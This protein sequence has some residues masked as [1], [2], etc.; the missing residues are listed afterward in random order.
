MDLS[1]PPSVLVPL[2]HSSCSTFGFFY[3]RAPSLAPALLS[4]TFALSRAFFALP[5]SIKR[6]Y[7]TNS[8]NRGYTPFDDETLHR[9]GEKAVRRGDTKEGF[10]IG[11]DREEDSTRPLYGR[12]MRVS[13]DHVSGWNEGMEAYMKEA[14]AVGLRLVDLLYLALH[15]GRDDV[16]NW[17]RASGCFDDPVAVLRPLHYDERMSS[18]EGGQMGA[19]AHCDYGMLTLLAMDE[20]P[21]LQICMAD[22]AWLDI[23]P[24][25]SAVVVNCGDM[26][27]RWSNGRYRSTLH[28][29]LNVSG[30]HRYSLPFFFE[31]N[32]DCVVSPLPSCCDDGRPP[33]FPPVTSGRYLMGRYSETQKR[34]QETAAAATSSR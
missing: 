9:V 12:N 29:V 23:P 1:L 8:A 27:E 3:L 14:T 5:D 20:V 25:E 31:P 19:G 2:L 10:Y 28:R 4:N 24:V 7:L 32:F 6:L 22:G 34:Y 21:G 26:L 18:E 16:G 17:R 33:L 30:R 11:V 15:G 13:D